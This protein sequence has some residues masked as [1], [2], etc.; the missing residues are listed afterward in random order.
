MILTNNSAALISISKP[1]GGYYELIPNG[2]PVTVKDEH[3]TDGVQSLI[4]CGDINQKPEPKAI[5]APESEA[6]KE[7][8]E[9]KPKQTS[10]K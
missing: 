6:E 9:I 5:Q 1:E 2:A 8:E 10:K 4:D 3:I 7:V